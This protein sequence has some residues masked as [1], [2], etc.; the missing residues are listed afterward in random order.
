MVGGTASD[1]GRKDRIG[2]Q[3]KRSLRT[4]PFERARIVSDLLGNSVPMETV[5]ALDLA[6]DCILILP[7]SVDG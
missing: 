2:L 3:S 1:F 7:W 5:T 4:R 6:L